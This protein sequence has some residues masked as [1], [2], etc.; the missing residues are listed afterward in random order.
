M[1]ITAL[2]LRS[3]EIALLGAVLLGVTAVTAF[4]Q[5]ITGTPGSPEATTTINGK[6]LPPPDP[7][8]GGVIKEKASESQ[9]WWAPRVVPP[10]GA[11]NVL[12]IMT[13]DQG[14]GAPST[15]GG[16]IPTPAMDHIAKA[17]LR[18]TNF[19]STALCSPTR[20][21]LITGRNHH[22][23]GNGVVGEIATGFPGYD[24]II[25]I[26]KGTIGTILKANGYATSWFGKDH[27]TPSYQSSQAGPFNQWPNGMGFDYFYG[28]VGGDANQ[29]QPNL[30]RNTT[31]IYPF[32]SNPGWNLETAMADEAIH[33]VKQLKEIAP[34]K[35]WLVY[36]VPGA[37]HAPH[38]P[39]PEWIKKISD[40]HLFDGGWNKVRET[41]FANQKRLDI[42]PPDAKLTPWPKELPEWDSLGAL[43]KK[44]FIKQADIYGAYLAYADHKIG[45]VIQ[46]VKDLGEIDNT[47]IIYI[48]GDNGASAEGMLN[49]TPNEYTTLNGV[50]VPVKA[51]YL[52]YPFWGSDKTFPHYA[53]EWAWALDTP[54]KWVKQVPSHFGGTA[55][56]VA[57]SWPGHIKDAGGIR[58]QFHHVIDIVPTI[59]EAA[60]IPAPDMING[61]KQ[62]PIEG[63]SMV[64]TWD[65]ANANAPTTHTTQYFEMLGNRA[66]YQDGWVA[67][68]TPATLPWELSTKLPP[69][70]ITGYNWELYN[71]KEDPTEFNDLAAK[72]PEKLKQMQALFYSEAKKYNVLPLDNTTLLRWNTPRP[73]LTTGRTVFTYS[74]ELTGVPDSAAP[75]ILNKSYT[76]TAEVEIPKGGAEGMIVTEGGRFGG[77]GLFLSRSFNWWFKARLFRNLGLGFLVFGLLLVWRGR[78]KNWSRIKMGMSY[79][80][81]ILASSLVVAV[82]TTRMVN[83]GRGKPVF[84]YNLLNLKRTTWSGP[85]LGAGKHTIVFDYKSDGPGLGKGGMGVLSVD[86]KEVARNS[87]EHGTPITFPEDES[88]DIGQDT[89]TGVA[90]LEYRYDVPFKFTGKI[91][92]LTFNL[93]PA[94]KVASEPKAELGPTMEAP[95]PDPIDETPER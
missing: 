10:K 32:Q 60:G 29:W 9:A 35:P 50:P 51:Q 62:L 79:L 15:F 2:T 89:R 54:F 88:F 84:L 65:K 71:V 1:K 31:A 18:Y 81:V 33:Y 58:R 87:M 95:E 24:S 46:A 48:G 64:Y 75:N 44:L 26:D 49:G 78:S 91:N 39:T 17:G 16:V 52:W 68:T 7:K 30:F 11:P 63:V 22:S 20:A 19:H 13:D 56:G 4:A 38:H 82:F 36:Y 45:R 93:E 42:M 90:M 8:F 5:Q 37:T 6:Q 28:F 86:G 12:L 94:P 80:V 40:M 67:A 55:Q 76:I 53:A 85:A 43:E 70:V 61:I 92:K 77:Y 25:P 21:A 72:M 27:N 69:D 41:I 59:L 73:S 57:I 74:G 23:V 3:V 14:F 83:I 34:G 66:I 47:L